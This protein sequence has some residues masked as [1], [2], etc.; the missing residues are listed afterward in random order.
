MN[1]VTRRLVVLALACALGG[2]AG[3][4]A[5]RTDEAAAVAEQVAP[6]LVRVQYAVR[7]DKGEAPQAGGW[8]TPACP[9]RP[10][11]PLAPDSA[12]KNEQPM[13]VP[14]FLVG[15]AQVVSTDP[16]IQGRFLEGIT[17]SNGRD[18]VKATP[19]AYGRTESVVVLDLE[20]PL[21]GA[22]PL[23]FADD[24]GPPAYSVSYGLAA[25]RWTT[26]V[27]GFGAAF[28]LS[29]DGRR[30]LRAPMQALVVDRAG[31]AVG[32]SMNAE[33]PADGSWKASPAAWPAYSADEVRALLGALKRRCGSGLVRVGLYFRSPRQ[34][35]GMSYRMRDDEEA[36]EMYA[37][38]LLIAPDRLLVLANLKPKVTARLERMTVFTED[39]GS[40]AAAF[41]ASLA[42]YGCLV[43]RL[44]KPLAGPIRLSDR[45]IGGHRFA[46][47]PTAD[48]RLA[49]ENRTVYYEHRRIADLEQ[50]WRGRLYPEVIGR[51]EGLF[52][53]DPD[54]ALVALP[55]ARRE[56]V[57]T[58]RWSSSSGARL[59]AAADLR[60]VLADVQAHADAGNVPLSEA[61]ES[62]LA[63]LGVILQPMNRDLARA[64]NVA[65]L[66]KD[67]ET[68]AIV[69][70]VYPDSPAAKAG[71]EA[72]DVLLRLAAEGRPEPI[73]VR[74]SDY[75]ERGAFPWDRLDE[76]PEQYFDRLPAP[77]APV[78]TVLT[79]ALTDLGFGTKFEAHFF[80]DGQVAPKAFEVVAGPPHYE[81]APRY[82]SEALGLT[83]R[84]LTY[85][86]RRYF[87]REP[88]D[89][90][91]IVSKI[92][93]GSK[94]SV[95]GIK[96]Y[97][98][99]TH[100]NDR[101]MTSVKEFEA[102]VAK[103][104]GELR[105][106]VKRMA[107]GRVVK[108][109]MVGPA[110]ATPTPETPAPESPKPEEP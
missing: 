57:Q 81:S 1:R 49:G 23:E 73:E 108:I 56:K 102:A 9:V 97:E 18:V 21:E 33:L 78:E 94:A 106:S 35:S 2:C 26:S 27:Q 80:K 105:L 14:G 36:T 69:S 10:R 92:E 90:G 83:V 8:M 24:A 52:L 63:W 101:P 28:Q 11:G 79:R 46:L 7:Y 37:N 96:P 86:V 41:E 43:A 66:T 44:E 55:V 15:P 12:L 77:W 4:T 91:V 51:S 61:E 6:S 31:G 84:D 76:V 54:G 42:D 100:V 71:V 25:G 38:G 22:R 5:N 72:G 16:M 74:L 60:A 82:K 109:Q 104:E 95:A 103:A 88:G 75:S 39:G 110:P 99:I 107:Q 59:T 3:G 67:G 32:L 58:E 47:L 70:Y 50:G 65:N 98:I 40:A 17:V 45:S 29:E 19:A 62:R 30:V 48:V 85:E 68:G 13:E 93:P 34:E 20:R 89:P 87:Q 64:H 53:F